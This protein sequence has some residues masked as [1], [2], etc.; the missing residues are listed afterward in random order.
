MEVLDDEQDRPPARPLQD[1]LA[2]HLEGPRLDRRGGERGE[3]VG[4]LRDAEEPEQVGRGAGG[5]DPDLLEAAADL[6][7]DDVGPSPSA[8]RK[9]A[10]RTSMTGK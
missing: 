7:D 6:L 4:P 9:F 3:R 2:E 10:R 5:L 8:T 1:E